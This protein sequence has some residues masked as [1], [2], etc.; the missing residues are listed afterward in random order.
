MPAATPQ[1]R[2]SGEAI[3]RAVMLVAGLFALSSAAQG[4]TDPSGSCTAVRSGRAVA[5][6]AQLDDLIPGELLRLISLGL[7][8]NL[9][10]ELDLVR[11]RPL[12]FSSRLTR[13]T[14]DL[15]ITRDA[16]GDGFLL[17]NEVRLPDP[18]RLRLPRILLPVD[19]DPAGLEA[20]IRVQLR[21]I[22]PGSL[23]K[24]ATW[25]AGGG[26]KQE[27]RSALSAGLLS[28]IADELARSVEISCAVAGRKR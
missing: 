18:T 23:G 24:M 7:A 15:V 17:D 1:D 4:A 25:V 11:R 22:T 13:Q 12:W 6:H 3:G 27:E 8:G 20:Q 16:R 28:L 2:P 5:V 10:V 14:L 19:E 26:G 9:H 21:V